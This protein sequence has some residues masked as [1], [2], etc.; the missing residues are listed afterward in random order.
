MIKSVTDLFLCLTS[1]PTLAQPIEAPNFI[2]TKLQNKKSSLSYQ[3][4]E[5]FRLS[6]IFEENNNEL[7]H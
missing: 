3:P 6:N 7:I 1:A 2:A 5:I 4:E